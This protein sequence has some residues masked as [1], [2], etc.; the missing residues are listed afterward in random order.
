MNKVRLFVT[1]LT[2]LLLTATFSFAHEEQE[3]HKFKLKLH[4]E[5]EALVLEDMEVGETR[6]L[7]TESG[8]EVVAT[9]TED[10]YQRRTVTPVRFVPMTGKAQQPR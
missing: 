8:K 9:R 7:Y 3:H 10:G 5:G 4:G 1:L 6:Q 2:A